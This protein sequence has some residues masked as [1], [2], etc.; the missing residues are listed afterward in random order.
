MLALGEA[1]VLVFSAAG[2]SCDETAKLLNLDPAT[3][4]C[5]Q[6]I[7]Q[8]KLSARNTAH[9]IALAFARGLL[10]LEDLDRAAYYAEAKQ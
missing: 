8:R 7:V 5:R 6:Q 4:K 9:A 10:T 1:R 3:V 2:F